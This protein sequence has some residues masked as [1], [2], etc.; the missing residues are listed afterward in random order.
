MCWKSVFRY[1]I[2]CVLGGLILFVCLRLNWSGSGLQEELFKVSR[3]VLIQ[4]GCIW[5]LKVLLAVFCLCGIEGLQKRWRKWW[6]IFLV[7][8]RFKNVGD[9]FEWAFIGAYGPNL[10]RKCQ[11]MWEELLGLISWWNLPWC[12]GGDFN[13]ICFPSER[14][15]AVSYTQSMYDFSD[16]ISIHGLMDTPLEGGR[17]PWSNSSSASRIDQFLFL[18]TILNYL[19]FAEIGRQVWLSL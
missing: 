11:K 3:V 5:V 19:E 9:Q 7:S 4:I 2:C 10:N 1:V 15:G 12:L 8:C 17:Y 6:D 13:V 16:F 18:L 14:L